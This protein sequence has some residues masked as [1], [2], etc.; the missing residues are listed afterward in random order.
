MANNKNRIQIYVNDATHE[1]L[2]AL[3]DSRRMSLSSVVAE[4]LQTIEQDGS[5]SAVPSLTYVTREEMVEYVT[6]VVLRA[7]AHWEATTNTI[8]GVNRALMK[9]MD[10]QLNG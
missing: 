4:I 10:K 1:R 5:P 2:L 7:E 9:E 8:T 3:A 6:G